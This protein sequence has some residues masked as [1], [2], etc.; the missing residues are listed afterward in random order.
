VND[1]RD[2]SELWRRSA[3]E[4]ARLIAA[5]EVSSVE[6]VEAHLARI[7]D[8]NPRLNAI[9]RRLDVDARAAALA[10][11][12]A[13]R[14]GRPLGRLHGVP[15]T[16]KEN[17]DLRGS[18]TT[19]G[20][21]ALAGAIAPSDAPVVERFKAA[22]AIPIGRTNMPSF[23]FRV[24]TDSVLHGIT[25]NPWCPTVTAGGS[26]GGEAATTWVGRCGAPRTAAASRR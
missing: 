18:P 26:S 15:F 7:D 22:G 4:L 24:T 3:T 10:A 19:H 12:R 6:V 23:A 25:S 2:G 1:L 20:L 14:D 16:V 11:D 13:Q 8:V 21:A 17:I 9:V 5:K